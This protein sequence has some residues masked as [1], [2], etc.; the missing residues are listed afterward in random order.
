MFLHAHPDDETSQTAGMMALAA[1]DEIEGRPSRVGELWARTRGL[2][3]RVVV[4][5]LLII[6]AAM[7]LVGLVT[8]IFVA[9]IWSSARATDD[10]GA[11]IGSVVDSP[12]TLFAAESP[13]RSR[14]MPLASK[15][16]AV[17]L[18]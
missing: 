1:Y 16:W 6:A 10:P 9:M 3:G 4:F 2:I 7:A 17:R 13:T 8:A 12:M 11:V 18:S 14:S 5:L 15:I